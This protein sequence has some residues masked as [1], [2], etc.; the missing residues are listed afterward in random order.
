[1]LMCHKEGHLLLHLV[2][3][4]RGPPRHHRTERGQIRLANA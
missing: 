1:V 3:R 2:S 4:W